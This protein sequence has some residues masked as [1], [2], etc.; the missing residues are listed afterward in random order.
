[1]NAKLKDTIANIQA[2]IRETR[3]K[4]TN[5]YNIEALTVLEEQT[6]KAFEKI[7]AFIDSLGRLDQVAVLV[8][9]LHHKARLGMHEWELTQVRSV[10]ATLNDQLNDARGA[11][12]ELLKTD[13][14]KGEIIDELT[15]Q[16]EELRGEP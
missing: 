10:I 2:H 4:E 16:I 8:Q 3:D 11:I 6:V 13:E 15:K 1:M 14:I 12:E 7:P 5:P 9:I